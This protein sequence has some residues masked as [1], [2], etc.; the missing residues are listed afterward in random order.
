MH[1]ACFLILQGAG[2]GGLPYTVTLMQGAGA[3]FMLCT[4]HCRVQF[5]TSLVVVAPAMCVV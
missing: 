4:A 2:A 3:G 1:R 5:A